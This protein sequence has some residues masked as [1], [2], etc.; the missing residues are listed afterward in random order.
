MTLRGFGQLASITKTIKCQR[1]RRV[2]DPRTRE[3][4][5]QENELILG[6]KHVLLASIQYPLCSA[7]QP[8]QIIEEFMTAW[9]EEKATDDYKKRV[10]MSE[11]ATEERKQLKK[12][13]H[14]SAA[15]FNAR[16]QDQQ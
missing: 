6:N 8:A 2:H 12:W 7:A 4:T 11:K 5:A 15:K 10:R 14:A 13:A 3:Q 1:L 16:H 9:E